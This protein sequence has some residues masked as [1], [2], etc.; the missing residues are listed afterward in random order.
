M[1]MD[2]PADEA[3]LGTGRRATAEAMAA[4]Q[5]MIDMAVERLQTGRPSLLDELTGA[6][7]F[8]KPECLQRTGSF[9]FRGAYN[10]ISALPDPAARA[11][12][13]TSAACRLARH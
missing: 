4:K 10:A 5:A 7:V 12:L 8:L 13:I 6:T 11:E 3:K 1:T 2:V 9:K